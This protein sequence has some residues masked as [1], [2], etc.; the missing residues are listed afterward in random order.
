MARDKWPVMCVVLLALSLS[1]AVLPGR[2]AAEPAVPKALADWR[3]WVLHGAESHRCP[4]IAGGEGRTCVFPGFLQLDLQAQSGGRFVME[5]TA[6][7]ADWLH[8]PGDNNCWPTAVTLDG[9][10][11]VVTARNGRPALYLG[12]GPHRVAGMYAWTQQPDGLTLPD[13]LAHVQLTMDGAAVPFPGRDDKGRLWL[14]AH[15]SSAGE[16][17]EVNVAV[18]RKIADGVPMIITAQIV[19]RVSGRAR[20]LTLE[21]ALLPDTLPLSVSGDIPAKLDDSGKMRVQAQAGTHV[22]EVVART[23]GNPAS[24]ALPPRVAPWPQEEFWA[25]AADEALRQVSLSGAVPTDPTR[26]PMSEDWYALPAFVVAQ[27]AAL[28]IETL[29][30]GEPTPPPGRLSVHRNIW[31]DMGGEGYSVHDTLE[32]TLHQGGRLDLSRG[33]LGQAQLKTPQGWESQLITHNPADGQAGV[34]I[35]QRDFQLRSDW[36]IEGSA[37]ELPAVSWS[38][39]VQELSVDL[40]LPPGWRLLTARGVDDV[41]DTFWDN[42]NLFSFFFVLI[43]ALAIGRLTHWGFG[44]LA[45]V[46]LALSYQEPDAP[47][48]AWIFLLLTVAL[49]RVLPQGRAHK[50]GVWLFWASVVGIAAVL[51]VFSVYQIRHGLYPQTGDPNSGISTHF[52]GMGTADAPSPAEVSKRDIE[53]EEALAVRRPTGIPK[54]GMGLLAGAVLDGDASFEEVDG[55]PVEPEEERDVAAEE[56]K[57]AAGTPLQTRQKEA[58]VPKAKGALSR[59]SSSVYAYE[60][61][62]ADPKS[63]IQTGPGMPKWSWNTWQLRWSGPVGQAH[64][65]KLYLLSPAV[66][67][68]LSILRVL[69][70]VALCLRLVWAGKK[71]PPASDDTLS[72]MKARALSPFVSLGLLLALCAVPLRAHADVIPPD[73]LLSELRSRLLAPPICAPQCL[74]NAALHVRLGPDGHLSLTAEVH[75]GAALTWP[76][77]G[78]VANWSPQEIR[79]DGRKTDATRLM[80]DGFVHVRI[81]TAGR[82]QV[83]VTGPVPDAPSLTLEIPGGTRRVTQ[84]LDGWKLE[85]LRA[86]G[87]LESSL[88]LV[89]TALAKEDAAETERAGFEEGSYPP[90]FTVTRTL[91]VGVLWQVQTRVQRQSPVGTPLVVRIPLLPGE[92]V[93]DEAFP[94]EAAH[95]VVSLGRNESEVSWRSTLPESPQMTLQAAAQGAWSEVWDIR[96]GRIWQC[97]FSGIAPVSTPQGDA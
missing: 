42:W 79:I 90:W 89:R 64:S 62:F 85:G 24:L 8:L 49:L 6:D 20:E 28:H 27:G 25:F 97:H 63:V 95:L 37:R 72:R 39:D 19:L 29:R 18:V 66:N 9:K 12:T 84:E 35:R 52:A 83:T 75:A 13:G 21:G 91:D 38:Q 26:T 69:L 88:L 53:R 17:D 11:A 32:G 54:T 71:T 77:P 51:A 48:F 3:D 10:P 86:A 92:S 74:E 50:T 73:N 1:A 82:H 45:L 58:K 43:M 44:L 80:P 33:I 22:I 93:V 46:A 7:A 81:P 47:F 87:S 15:A 61:E 94:V 31:L 40:H 78:P 70:L 67:L 2:S 59:L 76:I 41:S 65:L 30:R 16:A 34:E 4:L 57:V 60:N 55:R 14:K 5:V 56:A 96:C 23:A 36:R 68:L